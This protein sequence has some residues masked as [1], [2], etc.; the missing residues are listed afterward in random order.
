[1][2][3]KNP[4][5]ARRNA[6]KPRAKSGAKLGAK[7]WGGRFAEGTDALIEAFTES[8]SHDH[9]LAEADIRGSIAHAKGLRRAGVLSPAELKRIVDGLRKIDDE[10]R[11]GAFPWST[12]LEDVHMNIE[13]RLI[14]KIGLAGKKLHTG[15]S[16]NDQVATDERLVLMEQADDLAKKIRALQ[17]AVVGQAEGGVEALMPGLTHLQIAQ[18]VSFAHHMLA[19]FE[20]LKRDVAR[21]ADARR[22]MNVMPLGSA[23]LAGTNYPIDRAYV[24]KLLGFD[25]VSDNS[26]DAV[27]DRDFIVELAAVCA[28]TMMHLSRFAE[29][30]IL[31]TSPAFGFVVLPDRCCTGSS[32]MP[33]KK[34][35]DAAELV[36]GKTGR[37]YGD[38][39]ALLT[40]MKAQPLAYNRDNQED[41]EPIFDALDTSAQCVCV[42][43]LMVR[44]MRIDAARMREMAERGHSTATEFADHLVARGV[45]FRDA[46]A[47]TGRLV[48]LALKR[49][50]ALSELS[51][52]DI[53]AVCPQAGA[54]AKEALTLSA[55]IENKDC[56]GGVATR[57]VR[58]R[59]RAA[60]NE[61]RRA[62][63][64]SPRRARRP[65]SL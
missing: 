41:K 3:T 49:G 63:S 40:L 22:R 56:H 16:R 50:V 13:A 14:K 30:L 64:H 17:A 38:L 27:S 24:A 62:A 44:A 11:G 19:W 8:V 42:M 57:R 4:R 54:R 20:M 58:A 18:P 7:L 47:M 1:M 26:L 15:R 10:I 2:A 9:R 35:P 33:Q 34:N 25:A 28:M 46:H 65:T 61:L 51:A 59:I 52:A 37:V 31:W 48:G 60:K 12:E 53:R 21:L 43:T 39:V 55:A 5:T 36:R 32:I 45:P 23:A 6:A 29:E